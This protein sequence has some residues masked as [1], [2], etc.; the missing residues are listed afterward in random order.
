MAATPPDMEWQVSTQRSEANNHLLRCLP[1]GM[2]SNLQWDL[3]QR[4]VVRTGEDMAH[5]PSGNASSLP[6]SQSF[7]RDQS[8]VL[9][10]LQLDNT[11][12]V[13]YINNLGGQYPHS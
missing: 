9:V 6:D 5:Q 11:T 12:A 13:A 3:D 2:G 8:V 4:S 10:L 1:L 7:L